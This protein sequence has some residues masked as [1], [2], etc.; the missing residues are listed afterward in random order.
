MT[1]QPE[2]ATPTETGRHSEPIE[3]TREMI[4]AGA[5]ALVFGHSDDDGDVAR[6]V[7]LAALS[8]GGYQ[9]QEAV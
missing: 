4:V 1:K 7:L 9:V 2:S 5:G 6:R 3:V 8:A